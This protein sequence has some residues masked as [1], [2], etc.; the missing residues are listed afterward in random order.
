M[1]GSCKLNAVTAQGKVGRLCAAWMPC[2]AVFYSDRRISQPRPQTDHRWE[3]QIAGKSQTFFA[4]PDT[5]SIYTSVTTRSLKWHY[6]LIPKPSKTQP[7]PC[8][9]C[10]LNKK[11]E[12]CFHFTNHRKTCIWPKSHTAALWPSQELNQ[13]LMHSGAKISTQNHHL[14]VSSLEV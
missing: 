11:A 8:D 2:Y 5:Y 13:D 7:L 1:L 4:Y 9:F 14:H 6:G 12:S 10:H 3:K